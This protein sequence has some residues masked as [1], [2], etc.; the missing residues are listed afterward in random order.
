[1]KTLQILL[2]LLLTI[3]V[4]S[5]T[6]DTKAKA[7]SKDN[8]L[9]PPILMLGTYK[10]G[11]VVPKEK[12]ATLTNF[13]IHFN[14][15]ISAHYN[16]ISYEFT[17]IVKGTSKIV[18]GVGSELSTEMRTAMENVST[19]SKIFIEKVKTKSANGSIVDLPGLT[20]KIGS[21][22]APK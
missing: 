21:D 9:C 16:I 6:K 3:S 22:S 20:F 15:G 13:T 10:G 4:H 7:S 11:D 18:R 19:G 17:A 1:M 5:Q 2:L 8:K 12:I 14:C